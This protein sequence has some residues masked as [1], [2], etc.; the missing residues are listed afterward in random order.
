MVGAY[1]PPVIGRYPVANED[2]LSSIDRLIGCRTM[3]CLGVVFTAEIKCVGMTA[4][5]SGMVTGAR[6]DS[7]SPTHFAMWPSHWIAVYEANGFVAI[8]P[9]ARWA[10][11]SGEP[12][13]WSKVM[14]R[15]STKDPG[16]AV[17]NAA[18]EHGF[19]QGYV[20][21]VRAQNGDLG[22]VSVGGGDRAQFSDQEALFIETISSATLRHAESLLNCVSETFLPFT[23]REQECVSLL[24]Q[25]YSDSEIGRALNL[26]PATARFHIDNARRKAGAKNRIDLASR[27][28]RF[29]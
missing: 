16:H 12:T 26:S 28:N 19:Y 17:Y 25:G 15:L 27:S 23:I 20:T 22:L 7:P 9:V 29:C 1:L 2:I 5:A 11:V 24:K 8:D 3:E 10:M 21:P 13:S 18:K 6:A 14:A 4:A